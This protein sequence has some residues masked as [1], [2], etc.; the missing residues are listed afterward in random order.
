MACYLIAMIGGQKSA[1]IKGASKG[2][3]RHEA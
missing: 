1:R 2:G 3:G